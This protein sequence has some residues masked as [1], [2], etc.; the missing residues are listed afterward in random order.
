[1]NNFKCEICKM[2]AQYQK[3]D[4]EGI[5][6]YYCDHHKPLEGALEIGNV[7]KNSRF[8]RALVYWPLLLILAFIF[9]YVSFRSSIVRVYTF[10]LFLNDFM[11]A[12]FM[13]FGMLESFSSKV[14]EESFRKYDPIA[15]RIPSYGKLYPILLLIFGLLLHFHTFEIWISIFTIFMFGAQTYGIIKVL[16]RKEK[17]QCACIGT[18]F[19]LPLSWVTVVEN[20]IMVL[21]ALAM[22][23]YAFL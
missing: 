2:D 6:H 13:I 8:K 11:A 1:M 12:F 10:K 21:M 15:W 23:V 3:K 4:K 17:I 14:F 20:S 5:V 7:K 19:T 16:K 22:V 18:K 9:W